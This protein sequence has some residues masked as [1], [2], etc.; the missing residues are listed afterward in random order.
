MY[1]VLTLNKKF[2]K[3]IILMF[4]IMFINVINIKA[5]P[6]PTLEF[7]VN[8]YAD[9]LSDETEK[10]IIEK[11]KQ[12]NEVDG[13][14]IVVVTI[15]S[16][17][18]K[19]LEQYSLEFARNFKI[20]DKQKDNGLL[21]LLSVGDR[22]SR[23]EV[24]YGLEGILPDGKTGRLQ[25]DYMIPYYSKDNWDKGIINGYNAFYDVIVTELDLDLEHNYP[26]KEKSEELNE[27]LLLLYLVI[28]IVIGILTGK[29]TSVK[30]RIKY[31]NSAYFQDDKRIKSMI[32]KYTGLK[33]RKDVKG[34]TFKFTLYILLS[35]LFFG[36]V[37]INLGI[38]G[39]ICMMIFYFISFYLQFPSSKLVSTDDDSSSS[40]G[41][42]FGGSSGSSGGSSGGG[43]SFG[44]GGSSRSF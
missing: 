36:F 19:A 37:F 44:G 26:I 24:G 13:T 35:L 17:E 6:K 15:D 4:A 23:I 30:Q 28:S 41:G 7:Y 11:S 38:L 10:Y 5:M 12:L 39:V 9:V 34:S 2:I 16:L 18:G 43:G 32:S 29:E 42:F 22:Q 8:D 33:N 20:G 40:S 31:A 1:Q 25:D 14:Q 3:L 27:G 21:I